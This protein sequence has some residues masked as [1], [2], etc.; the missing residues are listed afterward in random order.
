MQD[1]ELLTAIQASVLIN[2][3]PALRFLESSHPV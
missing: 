2:R 1:L 3:H